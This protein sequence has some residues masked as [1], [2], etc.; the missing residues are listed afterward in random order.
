MSAQ[1]ATTPPGVFDFLG[2][3][4]ELRNRVYQLHLSQEDEV[5]YIY[6]Q[7]IRGPGIMCDTPVAKLLLGVNILRVCRQIYDEAVSFAYAD[8]LWS[9]GEAPAA[10]DSTGID[11]AQRLTCIPHY[12]IGRVEQVRLEIEIDLRLP[13]SIVTPVAMGDL[14]R[15]KSLKILEL[16]VG[17]DNMQPHLPK[18]YGYGDYSLRNSPFLVGLV[19]GVLSQLPVQ[20]EVV[21]VSTIKDLLGWTRYEVDA[22]LEHIAH[23]FGAIKGCSC[24]TS[25]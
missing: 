8:R 5:N 14:T 3:P 1:I 19:C 22:E 6:S 20:V 21:W 23:K 4:P 9:L 25:T 17:L 24:A 13:T 2:L 7:G 10:L 16:F 12:T 15:L 11:C 18:M